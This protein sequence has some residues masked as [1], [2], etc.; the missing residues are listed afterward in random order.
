MR[1]QIQTAVMAVALFGAV[2]QLGAAQFPWELATPVAPPPINSTQARAPTFKTPGVE[3]PTR[4][5]PGH[6]TSHGYVPA[7]ESQGPVHV[8]AEPGQKSNA[9]VPGHHDA[10][11]A[12]VPGHPE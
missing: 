1:I 4:F 9:W 8:P 12:W 7:Y 6:E 3:P 11:G 5:V 2:P 10:N